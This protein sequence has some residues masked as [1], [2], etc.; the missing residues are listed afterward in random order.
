M[1]RR[2]TMNM[3]ILSMILLLILT[4]CGGEKAPETASSSGATGTELTKLKLGVLKMAALT[5]PWVAKQEGIFEKNGLDVELVEFK[6]GSEAISAQQSG[7]VDI[8]LS[9]PGTAMTAI[10]RGFDLVAIAQNEIAKT[11]GPDSGSIQVLKDS[12]IESLKDLAG[13]KVAVSSLHSQNTVGVQQLLK[14]TGVD[15]SKVQLIEIPLPSQVD[16][17]KSKQVD[18]VVAVDPYTT[19][20]ITSGL[21]KVLSW[22]YVESIPEQ[23]L[24]AWFAKST[25]V[26]EKPEVI[27][28]FN[29]SIKESID[30]L[31][32]DPERARQKVAEYTGLD[33][34]LV[35]DMPLIS[36]SYKVDPKKWQEVVDL[37]VKNNE[38]KGSKK[39]EDYFSE[40]IK[41]YIIQ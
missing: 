39:A 38:L 19:Q 3:G 32:A 16:A 28:K 22:N 4:A 17:L 33:P 36:W 37:M 9:I 18:A 12:G 7:D 34:K 14:D 11:A 41:S 15:L 29:L 24:G 8:V 26:N 23:P 35:Q 6:A 27:E 10:E 21:G 31:L 13:K 30:Y 40:Q 20:L 25:F 5:N 1:R 2:K